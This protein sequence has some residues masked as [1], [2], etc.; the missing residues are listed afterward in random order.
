MPADLVVSPVELASHQVAADWLSGAPNR[1]NIH[2]WRSCIVN[3]SEL[4]RSTRGKRIYNNKWVDLL[5]PPE[6]VDWVGC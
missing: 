4:G 6:R 2:T 5:K 3:T 1:E